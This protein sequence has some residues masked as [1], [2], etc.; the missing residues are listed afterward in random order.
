MME[1]LSWRTLVEEKTPAAVMRFI[2]KTGKGI[3]TYSMIRD[4][5]TILLSASGG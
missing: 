2:K 5:D 1:T 4:G 3:Y